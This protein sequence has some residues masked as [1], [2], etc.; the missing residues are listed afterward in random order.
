MSLAA[1]A[2]LGGCSPKSSSPNSRMTTAQLRSVG[3]SALADRELDRS[4]DRSTDDSA[5]SI[6]LYPS[7][8]KAC[9][10]AALVISP[11]V[12]H[13]SAART[14]L[15]S[16][17]EA[18]R[19][20]VLQLARLGGSS[21]ASTSPLLDSV[22]ALVRMSPY[23]QPNLTP[24]VL[25][26]SWALVAALRL[27][28]DGRMRREFEARLRSDG[29]D[30]AD[31]YGGDDDARTPTQPLLRWIYNRVWKTAPALAGGRVS[32]VNSV[33]V[34]REGCVCHAGL[35]SILL[36]ISHSHSQT[37]DLGSGRIFNSTCIPFS[38]RFSLRVDVNGTAVAEGTNRT[39]V[40]FTECVLLDGRLVLR[41]PEMLRARSGIATLYVDDVVRISQGDQ[42]TL[43]ITARVER[44]QGGE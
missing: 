30:A 27:G 13:S 31:D 11:C 18:A 12:L 37:I 19:R 3:I 6:H 38:P 17:R 16:D 43:F 42:G 21:L 34:G 24:E 7:I 2:R 23:P 28:Q 14:C 8:W 40:E 33:Q 44:G 22:A 41:F 32:N 15:S 35:G 9:F 20:R 39:L 25:D 5:L 4:T 29:D 26:G 36:S 1:S 10:H